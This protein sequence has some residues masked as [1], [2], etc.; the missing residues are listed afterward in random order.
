MQRRCVWT[1]ETEEERARNDLISANM[2]DEVEEALKTMDRLIK[3]EHLTK[4]EL[5]MLMRARR[6]AKYA[7]L[8]SM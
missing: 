7:K 1:I 2:A 5:T 3:K 8:F 6:T 4:D